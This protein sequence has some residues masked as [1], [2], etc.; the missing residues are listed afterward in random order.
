MPH[1]ALAFDVYLWCSTISWSGWLPE[2]LQLCL[3]HGTIQ[4]E[5]CLIRKH[6]EFR[7]ISS[8]SIFCRISSQILFLQSQSAS[9]MFCRN[10]NFYARKR[11]GLHT[12]PWTAEWMRCSCFLA[13][14]KDLRGVHR[15]VCL[16][17]SSSS[18][19]V[20][21]KSCRFLIYNTSRFS[22]TSV[23]LLNGVVAW[24]WVPMH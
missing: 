23:P 9:S 6:T 19:D 2:I 24:W 14:Q 13:V 3:F 22:G 17:L 20:P 7:R 11:R 10:Y 12:T 21:W 18:L 8:L 4:I 5:C 1:H 16:M 15:N